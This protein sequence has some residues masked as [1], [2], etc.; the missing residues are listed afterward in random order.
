MNGVVLISPACGG[1][2]E[3]GGIY[4]SSFPLG[5]GYIGAV[6]RENGIRVSAVDCEV[7]KRPLNE[8]ERV[9]KKESPSVVGISVTSRTLPFVYGL[10][11]HIKRLGLDTPVVVG[12][13]HITAD[14]D[15]VPLLGADYGFA[16]ECEYSFLEF[17]SG[18][19]YNARVSDVPGLITSQDG[20]L[21][22]N[23][24]AK[25]TDLNTLP[26]PGRK[27]FRLEK[28]KFTPIL[29]SRGCSFNCAFCA[30]AGSGVRFR[31]PENVVSEVEEC[32]AGGNKIDFVDDVFTVDKK[33]VLRVCELMK[34]AKINVK[35]ACTTRAD[36]VDY[37]ILRE[38]YAAGCWY[39]SFGVESGSERIRQE[40]GKGLSN[41]KIIDAFRNCRMIG[42]KTRAYGM[43]GHPGET[44][45]EMKSTIDFICGLD[46]T[47]ALFMPTDIVPG[48]RLYTLSLK[49]GR[50]DG[51]VWESYM[52]G[53]EE[54]PIYIPKNVYVEEVFGFVE[55]A[56]RSFYG[57]RAYNK[58]KNALQKWMKT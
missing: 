49:E 28:Y 52:R 20:R 24:P 42:I 53:L 17:L 10:V 40:I 30:Q 7:E 38:M 33:R 43:F 22:V 19:V 3:S 8:V 34:D 5:L 56:Y 45:G 41:K 15:I 9:L 14:P 21:R 55:S 11:N 13:P 6:L 27:L 37:D 2:V 29:T 35:W 31:R 57:R 50:I 54:Y 12:G 39:I 1:I 18:G 46:A 23:K 26:F 32:A 47:D 58:I 48:T 51:G 16:G 36:L 25:I 44:P 4:Y